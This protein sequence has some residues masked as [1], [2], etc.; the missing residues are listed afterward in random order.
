MANH[1]LNLL[2]QKFGRLTAV[3]AVRRDGR[4]FWRCVCE[5]GGETTPH[6]PRLTSGQI[7]SCGCLRREPRDNWKEYLGTTVNGWTCAEFVRTDK[8]HIMKWVHTCGAEIEASMNKVK[9]GR[10]ALCQCLPRRQRCHVSKYHGPTRITHK[11]M[12]ARCTNK[13][14]VAYR[15]Y[16]GAGITLDPRWLDYSEF[17]RDMGLRPDGCELDRSDNSKGYYA[18][19]CRWVTR[20][21]NLRNT[22]VNTTFEYN[23]RTMCV[24]ELAEIA[25]LPYQTVWRRLIIHG[26]D[27][28]KAVTS[29]PR[30]TK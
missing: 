14:H 23:G 20:Q 6:G 24:A 12:V 4:V 7:K 17:V 29:P 13:S 28:N 15:R 27:V 22:S 9:S 8:S 10:I 26:W 1:A 19:N 3:E 2:G 30:R 18:D 25:G 16:G 11:A 5:C 21:T